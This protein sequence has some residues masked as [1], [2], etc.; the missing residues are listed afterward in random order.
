M[1]RIAVLTSGGDAPGMNAAIRAVVRTAR[2]NDVEVCGVRNGY[3]GL[4][5]DDIQPLDNKDVGGIIGRGGTI[6]RTA[7]CKAFF[8]PEGR[9]RAAA[10]LKKHE[11]DGLV[12]IGG[13]G[14]YRGAQALQNEQNIAVIGVPGTIDNDIGGTDFTIGF[15]TALNVALDAIDRIR[16]TAES[17]NRL[18]F[19]EVMGRHSGYIAMM[20]GLAGGAEDILCPEEPT[21]IARLLAHLERRHSSRGKT[22]AIVVVAEGDDAGN[23][24]QVAERIKAQAPAY[25]GGTRVVVIGHMQRGGAPTAIDRIRASRFGLRAVEALLAGETGMMTG[26]SNNRVVLRPLEEAW[27]TRTHFDPDLLREARILAT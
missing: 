5:D 9:A 16:D 15:D 8:E 6:L 14:S 7:R 13:D 21:D 26:I 22:S 4:I 23:A 20:S 10:T 19:I 27:Q 24:F 12:V 1:K 2:Y 25:F 18:F 3:Q 11:A 17:H